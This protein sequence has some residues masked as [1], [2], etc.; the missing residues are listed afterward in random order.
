MIKKENS[1]IIRKNVVYDRAENKMLGELR[2]GEFRKNDYKQR[3]Y[4]NQ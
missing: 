3:Q 4:Q 2:Q 1:S